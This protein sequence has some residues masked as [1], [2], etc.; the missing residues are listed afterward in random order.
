VNIPTSS[1]LFRI[2]QKRKDPVAAFSPPIVD[3]L[4]ATSLHTS[5]IAPTAGAPLEREYLV[6]GRREKGEGRRE[7]GEGRREKG[8]G[9]REKGEGRR[10]REKGEG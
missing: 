4:N 8:E 9:R 5:I 10:E 6:R 7:K 3:T 1:N 2:S